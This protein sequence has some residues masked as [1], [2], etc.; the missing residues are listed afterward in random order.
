MHGG[1]E[2]VAATVVRDVR[3]MFGCLNLLEE[4]F[5]VFE[6]SRHGRGAGAAPT[7][8]HIQPTSRGAGYATGLGAK[9]VGAPHPVGHHRP[10]ERVVHKALGDE[11][12]RRHRSGRGGPPLRHERRPSSRRREH[13][14]PR[15][16]I[17]M[18]RSALRKLQLLSIMQHKP[19]DALARAAGG[20][21]RMSTRAK[22]RRPGRARVSP[23]RRRG[24]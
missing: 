18:E 10:A 12:A 3:R 2:R 9:C 15:C 7:S 11:A 13:R 24:W 14:A 1:R 19:H 6:E 8:S 20:L 5:E 17:M 23:A 22:Q 16:R 4:R 21:P